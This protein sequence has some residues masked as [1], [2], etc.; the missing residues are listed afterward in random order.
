MNAPTLRTLASSGPQ[1]RRLIDP[2]DPAYPIYVVSKGRAGTGQT[3]PRLAAMGV[4]YRIIVE[5]AEF[6]AY[7]TIY[8]RGCLIP[9]DEG[10]RRA[11]D[12]LDGR[13][14]DLPLGSGPARNTAWAHAESEGAARH[15]VLD[16]NIHAWGVYVPRGGG[17]RKRVVAD[18]SAFAMLERFA[19][20][21]RNVALSA[22]QYAYFVGHSDRG[23]VTPIVW[24]TRVMSSILVK[25][26]LRPRWQG[27]YN[28]D[29]IL[30]IEA[31]RRGWATVTHYNVFADKQARS[32]N[33]GGGQ[34]GGNTD[35]VYADGERSEV[36]KAMLLKRRYPDMVKLV[37]RYGRPH[38][39]V[40]F[41]RLRLNRPIRVT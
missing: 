39:T 36:A 26:S 12:P 9:V 11:Y 19:D 33:A 18:G 4:D 15:W 13:G 14:D 10:E 40:D 34:A 2:P 35:T 41:G 8:G 3:I 5:P 29:V 1:A 32:P 27:R 23:R 30:S 16:D 24:N 6:D 28:E 7:A 38:H 20:R 31:L 21:Y 25:T 17:N 22:H 37:R